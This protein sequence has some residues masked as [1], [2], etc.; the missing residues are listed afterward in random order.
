MKQIQADVKA[1]T[2]LN[3]FVSEVILQ[4]ESP[5]DFK[6]GQYL[7]VVMSPEDKRPFSIANAPAKNQQ[8]ALHIGASEHNPY[9]MEVMQQLQSNRRVTIEAGCGDAYYRD[10]HHPVILLAGGTGYSF[11]R[12]ILQHITEQPQ[13]PQVSLFWGAKHLNEL[14]EHDW[15]IELAEKYQHFSY[16]PVLESPD[17]GWKFATGLVHEAV[18]A[19]IPVF[20]N[21]RVYVAGRF[22]MARVVK[23][24]FIAK[25]LKQTQLFGDAFAFID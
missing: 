23:Q 4:P 16:Q 20:T 21:Q 18:L 19:D 24:Q 11:T 8:L 6:A 25:G 14:Y 17:K 5:V 12:A 15:L 7:Q 9:A 13:M 22:E 3:H 10:T 2:P 1:I